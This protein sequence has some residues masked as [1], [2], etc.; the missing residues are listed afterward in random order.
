MTMEEIYISLYYVFN[1]YIAAA[2]RIFESEEFG[3][4]G[5]DHERSFGFV[6]RGQKI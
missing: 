2:H 3:R 5:I 6:V 1:L 4:L